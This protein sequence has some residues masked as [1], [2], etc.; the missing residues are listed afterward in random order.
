M[1]ASLCACILLFH[2]SLTKGLDPDSDIAD[3]YTGKF[4]AFY[5]KRTCSSVHIHFTKSKSPVTELAV[6]A[7]LREV[8]KIRSIPPRRHMTQDVTHYSGDNELAPLSISSS[9]L[10]HSSI[11]PQADSLFLYQRTA[12]LDPLT[13]GHVIALFNL[14]PVSGPREGGTDITIRGSGFFHTGRELCRFSC[15]YAGVDCGSV[16]VPA[17]VVTNTKAYCTSPFNRFAGTTYISLSMDGTTY[18]AD[19]FSALHPSGT[20]LFTYR[21]TRPSGQFT[22]DNNTGPFSGGTVITITIDQPHENNDDGIDV[23]GY[24]RFEPSSLNSCLFKFSFTTSVRNSISLYTEAKWLTYR[25]IQCASPPCVSHS[26]ET[27][28]ATLFVSNDGLQYSKEIGNFTYR[29]TV[30]KLF[31]ISTMQEAGAYVARG[32]WSGNTEVYVIGNDFLPS[33]KLKARFVAVV[34]D[35]SENFTGVLEK[36]EGE[37]LFDTAERVRCISPPWYPSDSLMTQSGDLQPCFLTSV[38]L[39]NDDGKH[40]SADISDKFLYCPV[41]VSTY[42]S[43]SLGEGTPRLPFRDLNRAVQAILANPWKRRKKF[44]SSVQNTSCLGSQRFGGQPH[45]QNTFHYINSDQILL[46]DGIYQDTA[47][48]SGAG[49]NLNLAAHGRVIE[50]S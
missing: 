8:Y 31:K 16:M 24:S 33:E 4:H 45:C 42:G 48:M 44:R 46:T 14:S 50:V 5:G 43:N 36:K 47:D 38:H 25:R 19:F 7:S 40:W 30:P 22:M 11:I 12:N 1:G 13:S 23:S 6:S 28:L 49:W 10:N 34:K 35:L 9:R 3:D 26:Y 15:L 27:V 18:S 20:L 37:C 29:N 32:P 2:F 21:S 39:S 41:Y 17:Q